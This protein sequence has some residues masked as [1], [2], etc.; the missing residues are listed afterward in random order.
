MPLPLLSFIQIKGGH[1]Q[2]NH[3]KSIL[4][5]EK[6]MKFAAVI[7]TLMMTF[8][9]M[10][11]RSS[12]AE[13]LIVEPLVK[14]KVEAVSSI[15]DTVHTLTVADKNELTNI[16]NPTIDKSVERGVQEA[17]INQYQEEQYRLYVNRIQCDP[18]NV[19]K[20]TN[21]KL[22]DMHLLT[23]GTWWSGYEE[24]L[25]YL[26]QR[27]GINA[28]FAMAVSSLESGGG[29][30]ALARQSN[31]YYGLMTGNKYASRFDCTMYFGDLMNRKYVGNSKISVYS[32]GP[33]YC[34]PN[35][36]WEVYMDNYMRTH[37]S[38][39]KSR[40]NERGLTEV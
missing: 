26:E 37:Y 40:I 21:L 38:I 33:K 9:I 18:S 25:Y 10:I 31:N 39:L 28:I 4:K 30:S 5:T 34:P 6:R 13:E 36:Q 3:R 22:E 24:S 29:T 2:M 15:D 11:P 1:L 32:I 14:S 7:V 27:Y 23:E 8:I 20:I 12:N 19:S 16:N 35:R 17:L